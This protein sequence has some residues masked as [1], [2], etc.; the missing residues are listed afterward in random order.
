[1]LKKL[2]YIDQIQTGLIL[3]LGNFTCNTPPRGLEATIDSFKP[4]NDVFPMFSRISLD[5]YDFHESITA[6]PLCVP[7]NGSCIPP[8]YIKGAL[9]S[10]QC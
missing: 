4:K 3:H 6:E 2:I 8:L 1:M 5:G 10:P 9:S 7:N